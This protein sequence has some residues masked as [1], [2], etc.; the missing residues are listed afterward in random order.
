[1]RCPGCWNPDFL[2]FEGGETQ[3]SAEIAAR[4]VAD[5]GT[6]GVTFSGGEPFAHAAGLADVAERVRAAGKSVV[7]FTGYD[8]SVLRKA[9]DATWRALIAAADALIAGPYRRE[10]P[11]AGPLVS[12]A[13][14][15]IVLLT[16]RYRREDFEC[17]GRRRAEIRIVADGS[18]T[19]TGFP[20]DLRAAS[21]GDRP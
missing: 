21:R 11:A 16:T 6:E 9:T 12:S 20:G 4:V 2:P 18:L 15:E 13:N 10:L 7:V 17:D 8:G 3:S 1:L 5:A 19:M 14:Q